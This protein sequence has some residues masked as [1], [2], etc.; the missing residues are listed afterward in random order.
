MLSV[1]VACLG[2]GLDFDSFC[3]NF[4]VELDFDKLGFCSFCCN[5][6]AGKLLLQCWCWAGFLQFMLL[7]VLLRMVL[8]M[9]L[10]VVLSSNCVDDFLA[11]GVRP[12]VPLR[13][14]NGRCNQLVNQT[15][16]LHSTTQKN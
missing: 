1:T 11:Q 12:A 5:L 15:L 10:L 14:E 3:C 8:L 2:V 9:V 4:G 13:R 7:R 16:A 6:G